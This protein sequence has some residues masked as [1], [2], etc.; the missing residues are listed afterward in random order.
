MS[1][2]GCSSDSLD[3]LS[4]YSSTLLRS[5]MNFPANRGDVECSQTVGSVQSPSRSF[6]DEWEI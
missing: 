5:L 4:A 6:I 3:Y 2:L 1:H